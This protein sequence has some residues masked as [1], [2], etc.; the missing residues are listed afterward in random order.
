MASV[1]FAPPRWLRGP[2]LQTILG[3]SPLRRHLGEK[4][5]AACHARTTPHIID[6]GD[7]VRLSGLHD[8]PAS[9]ESKGLALL[10]HGWE[11]SVDSS[12]MRLTA[13]ELL[14]RGWSTFRLNFRDHG[15][16]HHL[17]EQIFH[18]N[19]IDEVV[20]AAVQVSKRFPASRMVAAGYSLGGNFTL[21]LALRASAAGLRL[22]RVASVCPVLDPAKTM[23]VMDHGIGLYRRYFERK[24]RASLVR[25]R[26]LFPHLLHLDDRTLAQ[27][28]GPLT[29]WLV[30]R[31]TDFGTIEN[32]FDGYTLAGHRLA[33]LDV[34]AEILTAADDPVIPV[35]DFEALRLAPATRLTITPYGGHCG[36]VRNA[37]LDGFAEHWVADVLDRPAGA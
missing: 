24:W 17:N 36:F 20:R 32:Y 16:S 15:D 5:L 31:H 19:R 35:D 37:R 27:R 13:A 26:E 4:R 18:S 22:E 30:E 21:R 7:G 6:A 11:G 33:S 3:T 8:E 28:L 14:A 12:Y 23:R 2:H 25:K 9:G 34:P 1:D 10:L 29:Q